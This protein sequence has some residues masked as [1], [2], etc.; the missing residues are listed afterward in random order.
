M[1]LDSY[2]VQGL[3]GKV[4]RAQSPQQ[5]STTRQ[6]G[7]PPNGLELNAYLSRKPAAEIRVAVAGMS[8]GARVDALLPFP[9]AGFGLALVV[10][11]GGS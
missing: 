6:A 4:A 2:G 1:K 10:R 5:S 11:L 8:L 9:V 7:I 3:R